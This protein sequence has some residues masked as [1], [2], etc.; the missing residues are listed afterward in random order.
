MIVPTMTLPEIHAELQKDIEDITPS[1]NHRIRQFGSVV[2]KAHRYPVKHRYTFRSK[3]RMNTYHARLTA[4]KRSYWDHPAIHVY[5][6]YSRPEGLYCAFLDL[7][8]GVS[9]IFPPHFFSRYRERIVRDEALGTEELIH[10]FS[11]RTWA[12]CFQPLTP[13]M[14][15]KMRQWNG[16]PKDVEVPIAAFSPDGMLFGQRTGDVTLVKT[17][18]SPDMLFP[19]QLP[20]YESLRDGYHRNLQTFYPKE[21]AEWLLELEKGYGR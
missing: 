12:I 4:L 14:Q 20:L 1:V 9:I 15:A 5:C 17:I 11:E 7:V 2:L 8:H 19:D 18:V 3:T 21:E 16:Y 10:R 6:I 13:E